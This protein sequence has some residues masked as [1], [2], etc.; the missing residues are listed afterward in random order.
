MSAKK[1]D[2]LALKHGA[3]ANGKVTP[4][5]ESWTAMKTR[6]YNSHAADFER[7]GKRGI[8]VISC[9]LGRRFR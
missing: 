9:W 5:Y 4:E 1:G 7:Y 3:T 8:R 6:C 2:Q